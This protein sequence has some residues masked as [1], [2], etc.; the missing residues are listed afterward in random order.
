MKTRHVV[1][2]A[3]LLGTSGVRSA[4]AAG[5]VA[6]SS[7]AAQPDLIEGCYL[8]AIDEARLSPSDNGVLASIDVQ[9]GATVEPEQVVAKIDDREAL[10]AQR[11]AKR[12]YDAAR[13]K[14]Q[15]DISVEAA[16]K[17]EEVA[18][19]EM[20][21]A[22]E[23]NKKVPNSYSDT[24]VRR[25]KLNWER[26]GLQAKLA[27]FENQVAALDA[28]AIYAQWEQAGALIERRKLRSPYA[29]RVE[30]VYRHR[31]DWMTAGDPVMH[32]VRLDKLKV[33]GRVN[34]RAYHW[35]DIQGRTVEVIVSLPG[36]EQHS[37]KDVQINFAS[38]VVEDDGFF[39]ISAD[40]PNTQI[41][42]EW[43][44]GPGLPAEMRLP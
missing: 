20:N 12:Q 27:E 42:N 35:K 26:A 7:R 36:G 41:G 10:M 3:V 18:E 16:I 39:R 43:L 44:L 30:Q 31:G 21:K 37:V 19:A 22:M 28:H 14:A 34:A 15:N 25:L 5:S 4:V 1:A 24:E 2:L 29:G 9:E 32:I 11:V 33:Q 6:E 23:A 40:I 17:S 38:N 8:V 13:K